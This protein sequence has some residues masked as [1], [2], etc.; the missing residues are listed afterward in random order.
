MPPAPSTR[1]T[2]YLPASIS[3]RLTGESSRV[4][5]ASIYP[6]NFRTPVRKSPPLSG[7][8]ALRENGSNSRSSDERGPRVEAAQVRRLNE[9]RETNDDRTE[10]FRSAIEP[11]DVEGDVG[12]RSVDVFVENV[13][14][15]GDA[16]LID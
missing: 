7:C 3:P 2:R 16:E 9:Q 15:E 6:W 14:R 4:G 10:R 5:S 8:G 12:I 11:L 13:E 1:S